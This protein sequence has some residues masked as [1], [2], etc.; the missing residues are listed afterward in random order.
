MAAAAAATVDGYCCLL[1]MDGWM[2]I[3][4]PG[5]GGVRVLDG[6]TD[7]HTRLH[8]LCGNVN[9][10]TAATTTTTYGK[11]ACL[12][13]WLSTTTTRMRMLLQSPDCSIDQ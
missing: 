4:R 10:L 11:S 9:Q 13:T 12:L 1:W 8:T 3:A 7:G 5:E 2:L 6:R